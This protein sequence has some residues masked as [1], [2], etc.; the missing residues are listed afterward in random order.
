MYHSIS[1]SY[2]ISHTK[3]LLAI[4]I[5]SFTQK[6]LLHISSSTSL[7]PLSSFLLY[8]LYCSLSF[9][10]SHS[11]LIILLVSY[12]KP[13]N[14]YLTHHTN[15]SSLSL[16]ILYISTLFLFLVIFYLYLLSNY[17]M[18][19]FLPLYMLTLLSEI[20]LSNNMAMY[21]LSR[22]LIFS[23]LTSSVLP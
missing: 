12:L 7:S 20:P 9:F 21:N 8:Y 4:L 10:V 18:L 16:A 2:T 1:L 3:I 15:L 11:L 22:S 5:L 14:I 23:L 6:N 13:S 17:H 19:H